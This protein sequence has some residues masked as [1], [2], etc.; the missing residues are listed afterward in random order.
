MIVDRIQRGD[1]RPAFHGMAA[2]A[3]CEECF[4]E[5]MRGSCE[6]IV[7]GTE[8][9]M[10]A[11]NKIVLR[12]HVGEWSIAIERLPPID[13]SWQHLV[14]DNDLSSRGSFGFAGGPTV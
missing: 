10:Q 9:G 7:H 11:R 4:A 5:D 1:D 14:I 3:M 13:D 2:A 8:L 6:N 12:I